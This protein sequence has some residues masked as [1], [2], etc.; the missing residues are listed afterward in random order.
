MKEIKINKTKNDNQLIIDVKLPERKYVRDPV[1]T[2]SNS[3]LLQYLSEQNI[4]LEEY[5][6]TSQTHKNLT[7]YATKGV[8]PKLEG[9]WIFEKKKEE[10]EEI[11]ENNLNKKESQSYKKSKVKK[12]GD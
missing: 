7:S 11:E 8:E 4:S 5:D 10:K 6:L 9:T 1:Q 12:S 2:F 3:E